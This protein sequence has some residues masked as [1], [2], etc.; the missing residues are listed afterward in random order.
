MTLDIHSGPRAKKSLGQNFLQDKNIAN[1]I[2]DELGIE[3]DD[4]VLEIGPGP[5]AL[6]H[7]IH[8]RKPAWFTILEKDHH[9]A[10]EHRKNPPVGEPELNV[11]LTDA[12]LFP[13][14]NLAEGQP[15]KII[16][17]LPYNVA[18]PLMWDILS[19]APGLIRAVFMIQKEV[20]DRITAAPD[21]KQY[22]GLSVWLQSFCKPKRA[23]IVPPTVFKPRPKVDS[24]V[25]RFEPYPKD[26]LDF[27]PA[28]LSWLI[29]VCFQ[30]RR[31]Q[32]QTIL[33]GYFGERL[34]EAFAAADVLPMSRPENLTPRQFQILATT[35][36]NW[37]PA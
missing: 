4:K 17:N 15:W 1:R 33:K 5:G 31:K 35:V 26:A 24:A 30:Q 9:W 12:L 22:G 13:W 8:A 2:V 7:L 32:M 21:S 10:T 37:I 18:S 3:P 20:G 27:D 34:E 6:T 14:E 28:A 16:G 19:R 23:F 11:V 36:K 25:L 29:K